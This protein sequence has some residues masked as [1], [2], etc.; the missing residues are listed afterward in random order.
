[1]RRILSDSRG[2]GA[3]EFAFMAPVLGL[4]ALGISD[5]S[6]GL[7]R[8]YKIEQASYRAL[9]MIT[10]GDIQGGYAYVAPEAAA[11][12]DVPED[13]ITV[14]TK[15]ECDGVEK[16][17]SDTCTAAQETAR[18]ITVTIFDDYRPTFTYSPLGR[19]ADGA[20]RLTARST[21]R[22]Q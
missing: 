11:A 10:V 19:A 3:I 17:F 21:I 20:I 5:L 13:N 16:P 7:A 8:K 22:V 12:A 6:L 9:E 15:L 1:M 18:F 4:V 2:T 14:V